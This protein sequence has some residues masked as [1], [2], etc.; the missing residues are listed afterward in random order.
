MRAVHSFY[1]NN[2]EMRLE[3]KTKIKIVKMM[4]LI[5]I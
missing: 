4:V 1:N 3:N 5:T 2:E